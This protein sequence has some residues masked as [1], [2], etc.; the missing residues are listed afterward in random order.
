MN[1]LR[2][3]ITPS[4]PA[5]HIF[6]VT[7]TVDEPHP[8]GQRFMLPV[9][10][11][12]SYMVREF[13]R[14]V[15][16]LK[17][18]AGGSDVPVEKTDKCT[19]QCA[20]A[21]GPL[22]LTYE[23]Y[24]WDLSVR[25]AHLDETH[26]FF[27]GTSVFLLPEG[28][29]DLH[30]EVEIIRPA[31][32]PFAKWQVGSALSAKNGSNT[33]PVKDFGVFTAVSYDELIDH[34]V[35]LGTFDHVS[36]EA[37]G[38]PHHILVTGRHR[39]DLA[40]MAQ[41]FRKFCETQ[42]RLFEPDTSAAPMQ[43]YWFLLTV[44]GDGF[45]GLE[46]RASTALLSGRDSLPL[47][48]EIKITSAYRKLLSLASHEYFH[49]WNVK[50]IK[51][52][53]FVPYDLTR[54]NVTRQLW[55]FEGFTDYYDDLMLCRSGV[56]TPLEYLEMEADNIARVS[57]Q[58]GRFRQSVA[59]SSFDAWVKYYRQDENAVNSIVSYYQKGA[60]IGMALDLSIREATQQARS[61]DDVM[62]AL[63]ARRGADDVAAVAEGEIEHVV[64]KVVGEVAACDLG[65]FFQR[66]VYGTED[67]DL[68]GLLKPLGIA[69]TWR[70]K[71]AAAD[72]PATAALG[73]KFGAEANGDARI[74]QAF[75]GGAAM[76]AGLSA[77]DTIVAI[78]GLRVTALSI[79]RRVRSYRVGD[80]IEVTSFRRDELMRTTVTLT[81]DPQRICVLTITDVSA[82][83]NARRLRWLGA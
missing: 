18:S 16:S 47:A 9:W 77:G 17:A 35:E 25:A 44:V 52:A 51:P 23:V 10:I 80:V 43:A 8:A 12:G 19:W 60:M 64:S 74:V 41:D 2:Y 21:V 14:N 1:L 57:A 50:R 55:F 56:I 15:V 27:N 73:V 75:D 61:L 11:P 7:V 67:P 34:P 3:T 28:M 22:T 48:H 78:D 59:E 71:G 38:V 66:H 83:T 20:A 46:H 81:E 37:C 49:T 70:N 76:A 63:W 36:F 4:R 33:A 72:E 26:G 53:V 58:P 32:A 42:I 62:R 54:E 40:R 69:L 30:C 79:E 82:D 31:G 29:R 45:G 24:A 65:D 39:G 5:A 13:A 6:T 68:A